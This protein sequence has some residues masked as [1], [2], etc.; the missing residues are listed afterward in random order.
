MNSEPLL[1][2]PDESSE[3]TDRPPAYL[4]LILCL[5]VCFILSSCGGL[6]QALG[7]CCELV[8]QQY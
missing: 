7:R 5:G 3:P 2:M 6:I 8:P 1:P 4:P